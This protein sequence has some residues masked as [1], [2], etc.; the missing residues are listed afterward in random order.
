MQNFFEAIE[1]LSVLELKGWIR[2]APFPLRQPDQLVLASPPIYRLAA[3]TDKF[4]HLLG[5][6][7]SSELLEDPFPV[8]DASQ[9]RSNQGVA[10]GRSRGCRSCGN[11][12][13]QE[14]EV[15]GR[16]GQFLD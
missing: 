6:Q 13:H 9:L 11:G 14:F 1:S 7:S 15:C 2:I 10:I 4:G 12:I 3:D 5:R 16:S 8:L